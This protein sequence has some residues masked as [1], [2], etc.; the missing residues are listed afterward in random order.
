[1]VFLKNENSTSKSKLIRKKWFR[2][3]CISLLTCR[4]GFRFQKT[5]PENSLQPNHRV[6]RTAFPARI[7]ILLL[8]CAEGTPGR[9]DAQSGTEKNASYA[10][11]RENSGCPA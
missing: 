8:Q 3:D 9:P 10:I 5:G 4:S 7:S 1:M 6:L 2:F 11:A